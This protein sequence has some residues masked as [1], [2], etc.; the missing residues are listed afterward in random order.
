MVK[1]I[2]P[3]KGGGTI[4]VSLSSPEVEVTPGKE[5]DFPSF[6]CSSTD[7]TVFFS[8]VMMK[9]QEFKYSHTGDRKRGKQAKKGK[10]EG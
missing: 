4:T 3:N 2:A 6:A 9:C 8:S 10:G 7:M 5:G 1:G